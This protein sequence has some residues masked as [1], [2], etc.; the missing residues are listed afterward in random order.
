MKDS[1]LS[2]RSNRLSDP[3]SRSSR[4]ND[5]SIRGIS[6]IIDEFSGSLSAFVAE[7]VGGLDGCSVISMDGPGVDKTSFVVGLCVGAVEGLNVGDGV[8][9]IL[10]GSGVG[11]VVGADVGVTLGFCDGY[12]DGLFEGGSV[13]GSVSSTESDGAM[14]GIGV[15]LSFLPST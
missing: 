1:K 15:S 12:I 14:D 3:E 8:A 2:S 9:I 7:L 6:T 11:K 4:A 10:V 5:S 13:G